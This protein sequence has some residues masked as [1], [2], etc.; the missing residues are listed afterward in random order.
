MT[1]V[2]CR[3]R[4]ERRFNDPTLKNFFQFPL[5]ITHFFFNNND[6][7]FNVN[8]RQHCLLWCAWMKSSLLL[9]M[10]CQNHSYLWS[11]IRNEW[12][13][14]NPLLPIFCF[15]LTILKYEYDSMPLCN[16]YICRVSH[17]YFYFCFHFDSV[18]WR[19]IFRVTLFKSPF[20]SSWY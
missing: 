6:E 9:P 2:Y 19:L 20:F 3:W 10:Q 13:H 1:T 5:W 17:F 18:R 14:N 4:R 16:T 12:H 11:Y 7:K 15:A 8:N